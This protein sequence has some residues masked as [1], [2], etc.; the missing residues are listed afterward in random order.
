MLHPSSQ[1]PSLRRVDVLGSIGTATI[2][3]VADLPPDCELS[4]RTSW[5]LHNGKPVV[6]LCLGDNR[7]PGDEVDLTAAA[8]ATALA[9]GEIR[10]DDLSHQDVLRSR[11]VLFYPVREE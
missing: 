3:D 2:C 8:L 10:D 4:R 9:L 11:G 6:V 1:F 5:P 7:L